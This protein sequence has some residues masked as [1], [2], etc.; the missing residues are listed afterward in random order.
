MASPIVY[1]LFVLLVIVI[2]ALIW[3]SPYEFTVEDEE[4]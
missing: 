2:L 3:F 1:A 4:D